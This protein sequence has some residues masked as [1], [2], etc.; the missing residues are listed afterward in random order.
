MAAGKVTDVLTGAIALK[1]KRVLDVGCGDGA[2]AR[3]MARHGATVIGI[4]TDAGQLAKAR[5][6]PV[7]A[8]ETYV[9]GVAQ[10][11]PAEDR[12]FDLVVFSNSLHHVPL[13]QQGKALAEAARV[14]AAGG[15][16]FISEPL[17]EGPHH[18]LTRLIHDETELRDGA[19]AMIRAAARWGLSEIGE[20]LILQASRYDG[21]DGFRQRQIAV[22]PSRAPLLDKKDGELRAAFQRYGRRE[23]DGWRFDQPMRINRLRKD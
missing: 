14:L 3:L 20:T 6:T 10:A 2:M 5:S 18:Q 23:A 22:D 11:L 4:D 7:E 9:E 15:E 12:T 16:L 19:L 13:D 1:G 17:A 8:G 21:F